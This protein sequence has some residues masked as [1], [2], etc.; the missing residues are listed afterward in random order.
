MTPVKPQISKFMAEK[1]LPSGLQRVMAALPLVNRVT[2]SVHVSILS[3][4]ICTVLLLC[5]GEVITV[6][7][8]FN[9]MSARENM[10]L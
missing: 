10:M 7:I 6:S 8:S 5:I 3:V 9:F 2:S 4:S 1:I